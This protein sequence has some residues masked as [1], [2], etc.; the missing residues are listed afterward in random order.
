M[1]E[2]IL[3]N[4]KEYYGTVLKSRDD[5][6]SQVCY[7]KDLIDNKYVCKAIS[8]VHSDVSAKYYGCGLC[9]PPRVNGA[10]ILDLGSGS[11]RDCFAVSKL[12]GI[13]GKVVGIDMIGEQVDV[14]NTYI[15]YHQEKFGFD[16]PNVKFVEGYV[17]DLQSAGLENDYFDII[18]SNCVV[19][20][21]PDKE[22]VLSAAF[23]V[24]KPGGEL[25][26]S[27]MY[28]DTHQSNIVKGNKTL[29]GEGFAGSLHWKQLHEIA[30]K[31]G[32]STPCLVSCSPIKI[33]REDFKQMLGDAKYCSATYRLFKPL[34]SLPRDDDPT[35]Q[36]GVGLVTYK[37]EILHH[38]ELFNF[39]HMLTLLKGVET[40]VPIEKINILVSSRYAEEFEFKVEKN[41]ISYDSCN[42]WNCVE[43]PFDVIKK[44]VESGQEVK[45]CQKTKGC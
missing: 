36:S 23:S 5:L 33:V 4:V 34:T 7:K 6:K 17:E 12:A 44:K 3:E 40:S 19:N 18:I 30:N 41:D 2:S 15:P 26:F 28:T 8:E 20:L 10:N 1:A 22:A 29:W 27:D 38:E 32:Y 31:I 43:N 45:C 14:A 24:L 35:C 42:E 39:D 11:G 13:N 16:K 37:G 25:Y 9:I 21:C